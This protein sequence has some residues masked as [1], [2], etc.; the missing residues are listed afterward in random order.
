LDLVF[1]GLTKDN[2][3]IVRRNL[4]TQIHEIVFH[5]KGGYDWNTVYSFPVWLRKFT[6]SQIDGYY[7]KL[8]EST[9]ESKNSSQTTT[10]ITPPQFK[11]KTNYK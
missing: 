9:S 5:G 11:K 8:N 7:A 2:T 3:P 1:F 10:T 4:F 6:F